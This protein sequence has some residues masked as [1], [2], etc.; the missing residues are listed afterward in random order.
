VTTT[1]RKKTTRREHTGT[2]LRPARRTRARASTKPIAR[3]RA[4]SRAEIDLLIGTAKG[5][6]VLRSDA[7]RR[8][9]RMAG[10]HHLGSKVHDFRGDPR[11]ARTWLLA[12]TGGHL[13]PT[14]FRTSDRGRTWAEASRPPAFQRPKKGLSKARQGT[15]GLAVKANF[16]LEPGHDNEPGAWYGG[17]TPPGLFRSADGGDTWRGVAGFNHGPDWHAWTDG[18]K[19]ESPDGALLHSICIDPRDRR[20]LYVSLSIGGTFE[21]LDGGRTWSP[22]N[23]GVEAGFVPGADLEFGQDPHRM[24][25]HPADPDRLWQQNHCGIYRLVRS[26]GDRWE[27]VGR[28]M[29]AQVGDIGFPIVGHPTER[30]TVWVFPM[31][32]TQLWPR[33]SPRG[34]PAVYRTRDGGRTWRRLDRGLPRSNAWFTVLR[35]AMDADGRARAGG[36]SGVYFGTTCGEVWASRDE[37]ESWSRIAEHLPRILSLRVSEV[38]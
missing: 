31:D 35:Q 38:R 23:R 19:N 32:G 5:A 15:R 11:D 36:R 25:V 37:G 33:T 14:V 29:P 17:S 18:G 12:A 27:R 22:L 20:H 6:F 4:G 24:I 9:W 28:R 7:A 13:G 30:D 2:V 1:T 8:T 34:K 21:S 26:E 3:R 16:W 10:P